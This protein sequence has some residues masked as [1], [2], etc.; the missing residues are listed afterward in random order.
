MARRSRGTIRSI[1]SSLPLLPPFLPPCQP[2]TYLW[3]KTRYPKRRLLIFSR[4]P[5]LDLAGDS[6]PAS[7]VSTFPNSRVVG[8]RN[9][10]IGKG[11]VRPRVYTGTLCI[12]R[13]HSRVPLLAGFLLSGTKASQLR[14]RTPTL[15]TVLCVFH[16]RARARIPTL[17]NVSRPN[18]YLRVCEVLIN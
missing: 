11:N 13:P 4:L 14:K 10:G 1:S 9:V 18:R 17:R 6:T 15:V 2:A 5:R 16:T 12:H 8:G 3:Q 7:T